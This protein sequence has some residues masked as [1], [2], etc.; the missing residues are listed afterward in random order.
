MPIS[1]TG[2]SRIQNLNSWEA[3]FYWCDEIRERLGDDLLFSNLFEGK[4]DG[5][6]LEYLDLLN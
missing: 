4:G 3:N 1:L 5:L 2:A 6:E